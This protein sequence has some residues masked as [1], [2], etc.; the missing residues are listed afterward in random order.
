MNRR[1][2]DCGIEMTNKLVSVVIPTYNRASLIID[3]LDSVYRQS[4]RP[5]E[6]IVVDDGSTDTTEKV[7]RSWLCEHS[8]P[9][10]FVAH[11]A[12]QQNLGGNAARNRGIQESTGELIAF[13]DSDD[14][15]HPDKLQKQVPLF[16]DLEVGGVYCGIQ[17]VNVDSGRRMTQQ[18]LYPSGWLLAQLLVRDVTAPTSTYVVRREVFEQVG[19]FDLELEARQDWDMWIRIASGYKIQAVPEPLVQYRDHSGP[20]TATDPSREIRAY[21]VIRE[22]YARLLAQQPPRVQRAAKASYYKRMGRVHFHH[23]SSTARALQYYVTSLFF[24]PVDFDTW[25]ALFG[26]F[27][28][29]AVRKRLHQGWN[30]VFGRTPLGIRSH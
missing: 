12:Q 7:V 11:L 25:A 3:A 1:I 19:A 18:R 23:G 28:P 26:V 13:L 30:R 27:L 15:W 10:E 16:D 4:Y 2:S 9:G 8:E 20:R 22:K 21:K 17:A 29:M 5:L 6:V 24:W 14:V